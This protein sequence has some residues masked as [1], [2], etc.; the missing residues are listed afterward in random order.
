MIGPPGAGKSM[1]AARLPAILPPLAPAES[2]EV[3]MIHSVA[4]LLRGWRADR[5]APFRAPHHSASHGGAGR[6]RPCMSSPGKFRLAIMG[7][8]FST[9]CRNSSAQ[10]LD[11][12]RQPLETGEVSWRAP[13]TVLPIL[14]ASVD[15]GDESLPLWACRRAWFLVPAGAPERC[16]ASIRRGCPAP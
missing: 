14:P 3:S 7:S 6:R 12:L 15:R 4:G 5:S 10:V 9:N 8:C 16:A 11:Y 13:I 1:L 2:L